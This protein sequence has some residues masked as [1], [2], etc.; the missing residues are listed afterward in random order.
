[1]QKVGIAFDGKVYED[2]PKRSSVAW[3]PY[4]STLNPTCRIEWRGC[5]RS[6]NVRYRG[7]EI[8]VILDGDIDEDA[9]KTGRV[10]KQPHSLTPNPINRVTP[11][12]RYDNVRYTNNSVGIMSNGGVDEGIPKTRVVQR[13]TIRRLILL[14]E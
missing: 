6:N 10:I 4:S 5:R 14:A 7:K 11:H 8:G 1:M 9:P 2:V 13:S 3:Q 12:R